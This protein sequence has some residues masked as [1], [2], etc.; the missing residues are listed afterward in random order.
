MTFY[1]RISPEWS[2]NILSCFVGSCSSH[3]LLLYKPNMMVEVFNPLCIPWT[4]HEWCS[5]SSFSSIFY[6]FSFPSRYKIGNTK[7]GKMTAAILS[8]LSATQ[9]CREPHVRA[10]IDKQ[11]YPETL[12]EN[13]WQL[14]W[15]LPKFNVKYKN[16]PMM[17]KSVKSLLKEMW[18][19]DAAC[20]FS[21]PF[22]FS[23]FLSLW[24]AFFSNFFPNFS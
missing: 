22:S 19:L 7:S 20:T 4:P 13:F 3:R 8:P 1:T 11:N 16:S 18:F 15:F 12:V 10:I 23:F 14:L 6:I 5:V 9:G 17:L 24:S 2:E 21:F